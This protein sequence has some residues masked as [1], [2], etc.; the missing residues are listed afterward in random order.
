MTTKQRRGF[1]RV[2]GTFSGIR[3][4]GPYQQAELVDRLINEHNMSF[5]DAGKAV[6]AGKR[7]TGQML[8]A[9]K[10]LQQMQQDDT[11]GDKASPDLFSHFEQAW[12]KAP[13]REWLDWNEKEYKYDNANALH[14]FYQWI[15]EDNQD[16]RQPKLK[17]HEVRDKISE[18]NRQRSGPGRHL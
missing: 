18:G 1:C 17:A 10:G 15:T 13:L 7:K 9:Y 11:Y 2:S 16:S 14:L 6:G 5:S 8:R 12:V 3:D 4:W